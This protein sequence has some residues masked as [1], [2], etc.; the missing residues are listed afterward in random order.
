VAVFA[1]V[2]AEVGAA[3]AAVFTNASLWGSH[4]GWVSFQV[5]S[6]P[7]MSEYITIYRLSIATVPLAWAEVNVETS[8][9]ETTDGHESDGIRGRRNPADPV[10]TA[11]NHRPGQSLV[12][13]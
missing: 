5:V 9:G 12:R 8:P 13:V 7:T 1:M 11:T 4:V 10:S 6:N 2:R 3:V